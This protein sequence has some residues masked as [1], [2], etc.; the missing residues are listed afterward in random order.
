MDEKAQKKYENPADIPNSEIAEDDETAEA[1]NMF[2][3]SSNPEDKSFQSKKEKVSAKVK[4]GVEGG[5]AHN[6]L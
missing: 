4:E 5:C 2:D 3:K 6:I 1:L